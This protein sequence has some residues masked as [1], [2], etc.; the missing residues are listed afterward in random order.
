[1][2][3]IVLVGGGGH[4]KSVIEAI[5]SEGREIK[6]ILDLP[7]YFGDECLGYRVIGTDADIP[8]YVDDCEFIVTLGFITDP[9]HR[10]Q[11]HR[12]VEDA[13]GKFATVVASSATVSRHASLG[14][15]TV[16]LHNANVNAG[17]CVG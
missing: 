13:G 7:K 16:V 5:E 2:K 14:E 17:A 4:C 9:E 10:I 12:L 1:M 15:G 11:L 8:L 6:G 3:P